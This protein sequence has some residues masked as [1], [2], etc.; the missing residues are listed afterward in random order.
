LFIARFLEQQLNLKMP[1]TNE[2]MAFFLFCFL[3]K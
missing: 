1:L 3:G 2:L